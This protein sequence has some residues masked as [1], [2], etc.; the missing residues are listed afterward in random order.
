MD[1]ETD[2]LDPFLLYIV[3][4]ILFDKYS[5]LVLTWFYLLCLWVLVKNLP[6]HNFLI[7]N[8][9]AFDH[10]V[11]SYTSVFKA[12]ASCQHTLLCVRWQN[13]LTF[14]RASVGGL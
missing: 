11:T 4:V 6:I 14:K 13:R 5:I 8:K 7:K 9:H 10:L 3:V 1:V 2:N 12:S